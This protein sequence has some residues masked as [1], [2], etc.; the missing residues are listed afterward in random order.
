MFE[1][2]ANAA[3]ISAE[4]ARKREEN[5]QAARG[6]IGASA[7]FGA[8]GENLVK[9]RR[10]TFQNHAALRLRD[11]IVGNVAHIPESIPTDRRIGGRDDVFARCPPPLRPWAVAVH[12]ET[13]A[14]TGP[15]GPAANRGGQARTPRTP[16]TRPIRTYPRGAF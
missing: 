3:D 16:R 11:M 9:L 10:K 14:H 4:A 12:S 5:N 13:T 2:Q 8:S 1:I 7:G 15:A 6:L